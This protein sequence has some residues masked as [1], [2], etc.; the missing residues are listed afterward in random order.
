MQCRAPCLLEPCS[1]CCAPI[2]RPVFC[3]LQSSTPH[4][5]EGLR[6]TTACAF[7]VWVWVKDRQFCFG[8]WSQEP[9]WHL[10]G[11]SLSLRHSCLLQLQQTVIFCCWPQAKGG[12]SCLTV[13]SSRG[14][15]G[16]A[17]T[18]LGRLDLCQSR[19]AACYCGLVSAT[20]AVPEHRGRSHCAVAFSYKEGNKPPKCGCFVCVQGQGACVCLGDLCYVLVMFGSQKRGPEPWSW[21]RVPQFA[22]CVVSTQGRQEMLPVCLCSS[23]GV[24]GDNVGMDTHVHALCLT[25]RTAKRT[26]NSACIACGLQWSHIGILLSLPWLAR[27]PGIQGDP[28]WAGT[29]SRTAQVLMCCFAVCMAV[30]V[31]RENLKRHRLGLPTQ[32]LD[33]ELCKK[34]L[35]VTVK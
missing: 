5:L 32:W 21:V 30:V 2:K 23:F 33:M 26:L 29:V 13:S 17:C 22:L 10:A 24:L 6:Y 15:T 11:P 1:P 27:V 31:L 7:G 34:T 4:R 20:R 35:V 9:S 18:T 25:C 19:C 12:A 28:V 3:V 14:V 16:H 8:T